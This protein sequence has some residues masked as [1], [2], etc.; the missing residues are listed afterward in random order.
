MKISIDLWGTLI[1]SSPLFN[2]AKINLVK[3]VFGNEDD[4]K[5]KETFAYTKRGF[6]TVIEI[7]GMHF[8]RI[9]IFSAFHFHLYEKE[10]NY[11]KLI[12]FIN[13]YDQ[14]AKQYPCLVYS[15]ETIP[16]LEKLSY[17]TPHIVLSSNTM[18]LNSNV[19]MGYLEEYYLTQ[20][21]ED[22][23]FSDVVGH[24]KPHISMYDNSNYHIGDNHNTDFVGAL[25][26]GSQGFLINSNDKTLKDAYD[27]IISTEGV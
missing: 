21:F 22:V 27:F 1:K 25:N 13:E 23:F 4:Q 5:I 11:K 15:D 9:Q 2:V 20:F 24:S 26:A 19:L 10:V 16:E 12:H 14:I 3:E 7:S 17:L 18:M 8:S 6:N